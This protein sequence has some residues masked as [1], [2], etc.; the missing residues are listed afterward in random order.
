[1]VT[2]GTAPMCAA[3]LLGHSHTTDPC[4]GDGSQRGI[5]G[6]AARH[7]IAGPSD[8]GKGLRYP[9]PSLVPGAARRPG[10]PDGSV[11]HLKTGCVNNHW[12]T[13]LAEMVEWERP[14]ALGRDLAAVSS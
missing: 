11:E 6:A 7:G 3:A 1:M 9:T 14:A 2:R 12:L 13:L 10:S 5:D 8:S 4:G